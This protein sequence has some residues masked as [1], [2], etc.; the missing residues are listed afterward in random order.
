M[1]DDPL[2]SAWLADDLD[3]DEVAA[4]EARLAA[5]PVLARRLDQVAGTV[6]GLRRLDEVEPPSGLQDRVR[7]R[8]T[9][10]RAAGDEVASLDAAR[11]RRRGWAGR[12]SKPLSA[13][14]AVALLAV[15][16]TS[17]VAVLGGGGDSATSQDSSAELAE[18]AAGDREVSGLAS[19]AA[20]P[21]VLEGPLP[22]GPAATASGGADDAAQEQEQ[23]ASEEEGGG[24]SE[25]VPEAGGAPAAAPPE[26]QGL[27]TVPEITDVRG[28]DLQAAAARADEY[29]AA[30]TAAPP[31]STGTRPDACLDVVTADAT[32]PLVPVRVQATTAGGAP[33]LAH[34]LVG[35]SAGSPVLDRVEV[36]ITDPA[37]CATRAFLQG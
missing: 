29:R 8:I 15:V 7:T 16:G 19:R 24:G 37:T 11:Q 32:G 36:W 25:V 30:I 26:G 31:F 2:L 9:R 12:M 33:A 3:D 1:T 23:A 27:L 14:A 28:L 34:V 20:G 5:D 10:E 17:A 22:D 35:A 21:V 4:L 6:A 18:E 13:V